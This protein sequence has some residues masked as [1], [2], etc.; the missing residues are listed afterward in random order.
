M[1]SQKK[2][3]NKRV[4][5]DDVLEALTKLG[6]EASLSDIYKQIEIIRPVRTPAWKASAQ[7]TI[8]EYSSDSIWFK[9]EPGSERDL[10]YKASRGVW[11]IRNFIDPSPVG[12][13]TDEPPPRVEYKNQRIVRDTKMV[14]ELKVLYENKCQLCGDVLQL[15]GAQTYS[16]G[17]HLKPLGGEHKGPDKK[18]NIIIVCPNC[19]TKCD[20]GATEIE[21]T[22]LKIS[23]HEIGQTFINYHN[24]EIVRTKQRKAK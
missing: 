13:D 4:W 3:P 8:H 17:H 11:G 12:A 6:G 7:K 9:G 15:S 23:K 21:L 24:K 10:L 20:Y 1:A 14:R 18:P 22:K 2:I 19:H 5:I 16:E